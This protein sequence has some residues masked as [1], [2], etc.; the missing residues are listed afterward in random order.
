MVSLSPKK[1]PVTVTPKSEGKTEGLTED[2]HKAGLKTTLPRLKVL[3][4]LEASD[5]R[6][7]S[8]EDVYREVLK[9]SDPVG[10]ATVYR[11]LAQFVEAGLVVRHQFEGDKSV[12]ELND[13]AHHDHMVCVK[14]GLVIEFVNREIESLQQQMADRHEFDLQEHS[15]TLYG[16]CSN[17][18]EPS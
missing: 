17:C 6:H 16:L 18:R 1:D 2:L 8:A 9:D 5:N 10:L 13:A 14:C 15:L 11:V 12:F 7:M 4:I 3:S